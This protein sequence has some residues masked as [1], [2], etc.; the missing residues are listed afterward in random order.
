MKQISLMNGKIKIVE[1][2]EAGNIIDGAEN[3]RFVVLRDGS[4]INITSIVSIDEIETAPYWSVWPVQETKQGK[5]II[6]DGVQC[7]LSPDNLEEIEYKVPEDA[8]NRPDYLAIE[9]KQKLLK[10]K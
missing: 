6:R 9:S 1:D 4:L 5:Y 2:D 7:F 3:V 8:R 10:A